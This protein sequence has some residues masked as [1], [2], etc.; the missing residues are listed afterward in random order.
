MNE[1]LKT[2]LLLMAG[3]FIIIIFGIILK[4]LDVV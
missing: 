1:D 4:N 2:F 3:I